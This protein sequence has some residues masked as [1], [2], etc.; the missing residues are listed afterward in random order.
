M[1]V[2]MNKATVRRL[3]EDVWN[4]QNLDAVSEV[5][6]ADIVYHRPNYDD[7]VGTNSFREFCEAVLS[8]Y[9]D[10]HFEVKTLFAQGDY[11]AAHWAGDAP[12]KGVKMEGIDVY[13]MSE[14]Q[15]AEIWT[16]QRD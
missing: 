8:A 7:I 14:G 4:Q 1:G 15:I 16:V 12:G 9:P 13:R 11:V 10:V 2:A 3:C 6:A 5:F